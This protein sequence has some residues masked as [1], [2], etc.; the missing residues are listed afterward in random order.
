MNKILYNQHFLDAFRNKII[1]VIAPASGTSPEKMKQIRSLKMLPLKIPENL[2]SQDI[3]YHANTDEKRLQMLKSALLNDDENTIVW[4]LR[5]GYGCV[6]LLDSLKALPIPTHKKTVIGFSDNTALLL[7]LSQEWGWPAI[8]GSVL[9]QLLNV[10]HHPESFMRIADIVSHRVASQIIENIEPLNRNA[11][12]S[13]ISGKL[14]GGNLTLIENSIGTHWQP[15]TAGKILFLEE[16]GEKG[17]RIDR[18]LYH[19][20]QA[21]LFS[22]V[23]AIILGE[24]LASTDE[25]VLAFSLKRFAHEMALQNIPVYKT[26]QFGHGNQ[27]MP[28]M[29]NAFAQILFQDDKKLSKLIIDI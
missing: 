7:F 3:P 6:R 8:H 2:L 13:L 23:N 10:N 17:Y 26:N 15:Q 22:Q 25:S 19:L 20:F 11:Q 4:A 24:F 21:G 18:A 12:K 27:N 29:Y 14:I 5:G 16:I 1:Q 9:T 28:L